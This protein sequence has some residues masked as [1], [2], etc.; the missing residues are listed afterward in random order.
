MN[1]A[2]I[3]QGGQHQPPQGQNQQHRRY[4]QDDQQ[5]GGDQQGGEEPEGEAQ[6]VPPVRGEGSVEDGERLAEAI[7]AELSAEAEADAAARGA[8]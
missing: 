3:A 5:G 1:Q 2:Q 6:T 8:R 4:Q 7:E